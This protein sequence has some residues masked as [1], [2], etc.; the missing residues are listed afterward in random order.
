MEIKADRILP[1]KGLNKDFGD[2]QYHLEL[3]VYLEGIQEMV[4]IQD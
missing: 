4:G 1:V 3:E 2:Q